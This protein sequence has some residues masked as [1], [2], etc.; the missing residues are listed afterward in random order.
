MR[1]FTS[2]QKDHPYTL[3]E[4]DPEGGKVTSYKIGL[5]AGGI[6]PPQGGRE[7]GQSD[8]LLA[9]VRRARNTYHR[10]NSRGQGACGTGGARAR[11]Q[12]AGR[13]TSLRLS[14]TNGAA[15][16]HGRRRSGGARSGRA[17]RVA[18]DALRVD[19]AG[20]GRRGRY[21]SA[22]KREK[23]RVRNQP[24]KKLHSA[25]FSPSDREALSFVITH[26]HPMSPPWSDHVDIAYRETARSHTAV[27]QTHVSAAISSTITCHVD[28]RSLCKYQC[29]LAEP[30]DAIGRGGRRATLVWDLDSHSTA[31][32]S[33]T[34]AVAESR[35]ADEVLHF[36][37]KRSS[38]HL[39]R[40]R[41]RGRK[42]YFL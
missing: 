6:A 11:D 3:I 36:H 1:C 5:P 29:S 19:T 37:S 21:A 28:V 18:L 30:P 38:L 41:P 25:S 16:Q 22:T 34:A 2:I 4:S 33:A 7:G 24:T 13:A 20:R 31:P 9:D 14:S 26:H 35:R 8:S 23:T 17:H 32:P 12:P 42:G 27:A 10:Q 40:E 15:R 39:N